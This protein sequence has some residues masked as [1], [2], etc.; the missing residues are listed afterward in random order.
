MKTRWN[1][2]RHMTHV[3]DVVLT[4]IVLTHIVLTH[5]VLTHIVDIVLAYFAHK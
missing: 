3:V 4:H 1:V 2:G 5:I